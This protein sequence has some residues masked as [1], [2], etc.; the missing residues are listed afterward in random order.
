M[1]A[2]TL[3]L[4]VPTLNEAPNLRPLLGRLARALRGVPHEILI[5]DDASTDGTADVAET[6]RERFP[7]LRILRRTRDFGLSASIVD[8]FR[9]ARGGILGVI[10]ADLQHD[11]GALPRLL[12]AVR[13]RAD[14]AIGSRYA[15]EGRTC[16]W[17]LIRAAES[18]LAAFVT[19]RALGIPVRDPLSGFFLLRREV[20]ESVAPRLEGRGWKLLLEI[21]AHVPAAR[22]V[23]VPYTFRART[24]GRTKMSAKVARVWMAELFRLRSLRRRP[25]V[26]P[27]PGV[28][29]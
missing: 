29:Q 6:L 28:A 20:F 24:R 3:S 23:E 16:G 9:S 26:V 13:D 7:A 10:D 18:R 25:V 12:A 19:H 14:I 4:I 5:V 2:P 8:G 22:V 17:S 11:P 1:T 27:M 15:F 21:L